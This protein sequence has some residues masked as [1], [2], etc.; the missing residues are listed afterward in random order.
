MKEYAVANK[1][2]ERRSGP[3]KK[4]AQYY[5][6]EIPIDELGIVYQFKIWNIDST[7]MFVLVKENSCILTW[8][9]VGDKLNMKYYSTDLFYPFK[10]LD[11]EIRNITKQDQGRLKGHYL[12]GFEILD[13][14]DH[15][16]VHWLFRSNKIQILPFNMLLGNIYRIEKSSVNKSSLNFTLE[17]D[18]LRG[19]PD[20]LKHEEIQFR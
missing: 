16:N 13:S 9:K 14:Q 5:S 11:T 20:T 1:L 19:Q 2:V 6:V 15:N 3:R 18:R 8:L 17:T 10:Y 4:V 12:V 7:C